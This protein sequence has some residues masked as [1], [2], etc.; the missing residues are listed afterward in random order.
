M[1]R[2]EIAVNRV[3]GTALMADDEEAMM[4][5]LQAKAMCTNATVNAMMRLMISVQ[6]CADEP[7]LLESLTLRSLG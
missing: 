5:A 6:C 4:Y 1:I 2:G 7:P 3:H